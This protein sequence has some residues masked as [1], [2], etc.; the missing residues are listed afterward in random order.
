MK[1][2]VVNYKSIL[3]MLNSQDNQDVVVGLTCIEN[4][5]FKKNS[6]LILFLYK[7]C[8]CSSTEWTEH[9]RKTFNR[10]KK[11]TGGASKF[12][13]F[14]LIFDYM[15]K[16]KPSTEDVQFYLQ[17]FNDFIIDMVNGSGKF[18]LVE[19]IDIKLKDVDDEGRTIS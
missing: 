6:I 19:R 9:A 12:V 17:K 14:K 7:E 18:P 11:I 4:A 1:L 15:M 8:S 10:I 3:S 2:N 5:D 13:T 16:I